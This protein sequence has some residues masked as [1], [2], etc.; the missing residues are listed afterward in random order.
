MR[1]HSL[2]FK[3]CGLGFG[4]SCPDIFRHRPTEQDWALPF[5]VGP[6][7]AVHAR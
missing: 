7:D 4:A 2:D 6:T 3:A 5:F 1:V